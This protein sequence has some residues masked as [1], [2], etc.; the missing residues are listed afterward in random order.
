M[1]WQEQ[2]GF[3][4]TKNTGK[5]RKIKHIIYNLR[6]LH[7]TG[8]LESGAGFLALTLVQNKNDSFM[9]FINIILIHADN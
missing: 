3:F 5:S 8:C 9:H 7:L 1:Q 2:K 4:L 6:R